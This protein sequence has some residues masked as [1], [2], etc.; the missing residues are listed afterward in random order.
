MKDTKQQLKQLHNE[1]MAILED[2]ERQANLDIERLDKQ[3]K[4]QEEKTKIQYDYDSMGDRSQK[5]RDEVNDIIQT[6]INSIEALINELDNENP[7]KHLIYDL[8]DA[9]QYLQ[10]AREEIE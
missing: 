3:L 1:S 8:D 2:F 9:L 4:E 5:R 7:H 6:A 10:S